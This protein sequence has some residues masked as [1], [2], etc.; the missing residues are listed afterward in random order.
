MAVCFTG[1]QAYKAY[2]R[3]ATVRPELRPPYQPGHNTVGASVAS[4]LCIACDHLL[5]NSQHSG[6]LIAKCNDPVTV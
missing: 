3:Q 6:A 5:S 4:M 1:R 2:I